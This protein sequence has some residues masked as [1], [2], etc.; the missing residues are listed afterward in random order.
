MNQE[1]VE[2]KSTYWMVTTVLDPQLELQAGT[3]MELLS[4]QG[5]DC[6]PFFHPLSS[7]PAY[8]DHPEAKLARARNHNAY[9]IS[10]VGINLPSGMN[11]SVEKVDWVCEAFLSVCEANR[12]DRAG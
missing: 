4:A 11:M 10:P 2:T 1:P 5:I 7:L 9:R 3:M 8:L 6:R 12:A